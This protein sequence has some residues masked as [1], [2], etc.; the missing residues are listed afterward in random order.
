MKLERRH[1]RE[2]AWVILGQAGTAIGALVGMRLLTGQVTPETFGMVSLLVGAAAL[3]VNVSGGPVAQAVMFN[4]PRL[5]AAGQ[6]AGLL[7]AADRTVLRVLWRAAPLWLLA[8][9][10]ALWLTPLDVPMLALLLA[11]FACDAWRTLRLAQLNAARA[12]ARYAAW[13]SVEAVGRPLLAAA[14]AWWFGDS[15]VTVLL[16]YLLVSTVLAVVI[17]MRERSAPAATQAPQDAAGAA[18]LRGELWRYALPLV[19]LGLVSWANGLAD[20]YLIGA[21]LGVGAAGIYAAAYGLASRPLLML[22]GTLELF[23][24]P[25]YQAAVS[26]GD[27]VAARRLFRAWL[28]LL[29]L[30]GGLGVAL[31]ALW[32]EPITRLL[33]G[34]DFRAAAD[35]LPWIA[36]GYAL[37]TLAY[38]Y[39]RTLLARA[40]TRRVLAVNATTAA[41]AALATLAGVHFGGVMGAA[42][43]VPAYFGFQL[44]LTAVVARTRPAAVGAA[45]PAAGGAA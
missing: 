45:Q 16:A 30:A 10:L 21:V 1:L 19:P 3:L 31:I 41:V 13:S 20:R 43:A 36:A 15:A 37:L 14:A 11:L 4:H 34:A 33:L 42:M 44:L 23:M 24:R 12:H 9:V 26:R 2:M 25:A 18:A 22:S 5:A 6:A 32:R 27:G 39:E 17:G 28:G 35:L 29:A 38:V 8:G 40:Q 7:P